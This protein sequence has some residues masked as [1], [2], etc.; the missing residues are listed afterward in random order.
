MLKPRSILLILAFFGAIFLWACKPPYD[1]PSPSPSQ[2]PDTSNEIV[3]VSYASVFNPT[4]VV[5][6]NPVVKWTF[7]DGTTSSDLSPSKQYW[8]GSD[9]KANET[10]LSVNPW[11][12]LLAINLGY[13][14][15]DGGALPLN[16]SDPAATAP[17]NIAWAKDSQEVTEI[18]NLSLAASS[19]QVFCASHNPL[20]ALDFTDFTSLHTIECYLTSSLR[21]LSL[22]NTPALRRACFEDC[23]LIALDLSDCTAL[24]DLRGAVNAYTTIDFGTGPSAPGAAVWHICVR[25]NPQITNQG[26]FAD[27]SR[28]TNI[29]ELFI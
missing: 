27:M 3:F 14:A 22:D 24:E 13:D 16:E 2:A 18:R 5:S 11:S 1:E 19:L 9:W 21:F 28:F 26:L 20:V 4:I 8:T 17:W 15:G 29:R 12:A 7:A 25:D 6:G 23:N 10:R